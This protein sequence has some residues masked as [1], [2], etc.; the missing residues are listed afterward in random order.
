MQVRRIDTLDRIP[1]LRLHE[2]VVDEEPNGLLVFAAIG[3]C[4]GDEKVGH[5]ANYASN[6]L[7]IYLA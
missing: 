2:F 1:F 7:S 4:E 3:R 6:V 5:I